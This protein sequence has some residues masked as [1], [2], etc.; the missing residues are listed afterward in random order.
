MSIKDNLLLAKE[1]ATDEEIENALKD[2]FLYDFVSSLPEGVNTVVGESGI[3]LSGGQRQRLAIARALLRKTSII[4]FDESTSS[5]DNFAQEHIKKCI[6]GLKGKSTIII[7]A[8]RLST[9]RNVDNIFFLENG[10]I[11]DEGSFDELYKKNKEFKN[12]F[13]MENLQAELENT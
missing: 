11:V 13:T 10:K 7:V 5:L 8:H 4:I 12:M 9:I 1:N 3:K 6:D 2:S